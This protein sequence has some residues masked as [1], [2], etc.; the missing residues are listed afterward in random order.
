[1][2]KQPIRN[3]YVGITPAQDISKLDIHVFGMP[4]ENKPLQ[5]PTIPSPGVFYASP[6]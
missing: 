1:M 3:I 2:H 5:V 4:M 6:S